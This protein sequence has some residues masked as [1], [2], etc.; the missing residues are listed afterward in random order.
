MTRSA[1]SKPPR[2]TQEQRSTETRIRLLDATIDCLVEFGYAGTTTPRVAERAGVTRGAQVHH[3]GSKT[4]LV[5]AAISHLAQRR[6]EAAMREI[7][8]VRAGDDPLGDM[9]E[10]MWELHQGPL[11]IAAIELWVASRTDPVL[12][13]EME[14]VEPF[15]NNAVL[16]AVAQL[17]PNE[18]QRKSVRDFAYTAMDTL[19]GI[20]V[21]NF[22]SPDPDRGHRRWVRASAQLRLAAESTVPDLHIAE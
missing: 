14:K 8:R 21:A 13:A 4:D 15:V 19:R 11:L 10:F 17:V 12:A 20:L 5:V 3:F 7:T 18:M 16:L 1:V 9:L 22:I 6:T 2:R